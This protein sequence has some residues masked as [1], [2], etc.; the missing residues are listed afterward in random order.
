MV[1]LMPINT[2]IANK[3]FKFQV[4]FLMNKFFDILVLIDVLQSGGSDHC[5]NHSGRLGIELASLVN[6]SDICF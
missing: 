6:L 4:R 3:A 2:L 1:L 5:D